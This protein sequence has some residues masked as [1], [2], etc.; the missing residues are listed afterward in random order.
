[1]QFS[2]VPFFAIGLFA[3][4]GWLVRRASRE[5]FIDAGQARSLYGFLALL[6]GWGAVS[7]VMGI[8]GLHA[9]PW[10]LREVPLLWQ[11]CVAISLLCGFYAL[12]PTLRSSLEGLARG[13]STTWLIWVQAL[14]IGAIG[15]VAKALSGEISSSYPL[16]VGIPDFVYGLSAPIVGWLVYRGVLR[17][18]ALAI[19]G[20]IGAAIILVP[21]FGF[22]PYWMSEPGFSFIFEFPMVLA[23]SIVVPVLILLNFLLSGQQLIKARAERATTKQEPRTPS[24][25]T[26]RALSTPLG[27]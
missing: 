6:I 24:E 26:G 20:G 1:M 2:V 19:W 16:W 18:K 9:T 22:M 3:F 11:A 17:D 21:T 23:P 25:R 12:S 27:G 5:A 14:R 7:T 15:S 13:A 4:L 8:R 10:L